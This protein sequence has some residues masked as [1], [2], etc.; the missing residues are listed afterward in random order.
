MPTPE[1]TL[2]ACAEVLAG[3]DADTIEYVAGGVEDALDEFDE[4]EDLVAGFARDELC[5]GDDARASALARE[6]WE[7]LKGGGGGGGGGDAAS[8]AA[9][10]EK[11]APISLGGGVSK[12]EARTMRDTEALRS[13][14]AAQEI[15]YDHAP[16]EGGAAGASAKERA[17][18]EQK[19]RYLAA[20]AA[21]QAAEL[22]A[23]LEAART[24]A[25]RLRL[26]GDA[27]GSRLATI[28]LGPFTLPNPGGGADLL[29]SA[30]LTLAPGHRYGLIGR[31]GKGKS[32]LLKFLASR[33]VG[34]LDPSTSVH[35]VS[36]EVSL[37]EAQEG[38]K[39]A[40][41]VVEAD[42]ER[43]LLL[44]EAK[45]LEDKASSRSGGGEDD[46][47]EDQ[48]RLADVHERLLQCDA[49]GAPGRAAALLH[50]LGF[51]EHL[52]GREMRALSGGWRVRAALAAALFAKPG[53]FYTK[54]FHPSP[55][56][57]I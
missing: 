51:P 3:L 21:A 47:S 37:T 1:E 16:S 7:K 52:S 19:Q 55:G 12:L 22:A 46:A 18:A 41:L 6:L 45:T 54:V 5:G 14:F 28:E 15:T 48:K 11:R 23:E 26:S 9:A 33:R 13:Q 24:R 43:R 49:D 25:A 4:F 17:R 32:T 40:D 56:F 2:A 44:A 38:S 42:V 53:A 39:P 57:N 36:Q 27:T 30:S 35:Y 34:G 8:A 10:A 29:E 50:A 20:E 31:N